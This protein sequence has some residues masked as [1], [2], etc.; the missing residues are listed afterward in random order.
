MKEKSK[1]QW[2]L[3]YLREHP[4]SGLT[5]LEAYSV[6]ERPV[7]RLAALIFNIKRKGYWITDETEYNER[8]KTNWSRY[9]LRGYN[10]EPKVSEPSPSAEQ[11]TP[12]IKN[13]PPEEPISPTE[14]SINESPSPEDIQLALSFDIGRRR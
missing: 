1:E 11:S 3:E 13:T 5:Q 6:F 2:V 7:T 12:I 14:P 4:V 8:T 9:F 10:E